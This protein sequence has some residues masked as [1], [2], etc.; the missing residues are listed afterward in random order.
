[1]PGWRVPGP[2]RPPRLR[3]VRDDGA[4][5]VCTHRRHRLRADWHDN[6]QVLREAVAFSEP[7]DHSLG[8]CGMGEVPLPDLLPAGQVVRLKVRLLVI[9]AARPVRVHGVD[10]AVLHHRQAIGHVGVPG[11][12]VAG[13]PE[14]LAVLG[15]QAVH[16]AD[17]ILEDYATV[18]CFHGHEVPKLREG[19]ELPEHMAIS[20][21]EAGHLP[22]AAAR[23]PRALR[24][25][26][27][28]AHSHTGDICAQRCG[29][30]RHPEA[31]AGRHAEGND[32]ATVARDKHAAVGQGRDAPRAHG[33]VP[34][35][36]AVGAELADAV[37][38]GKVNAL[39]V[40]DDN[41]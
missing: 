3:I 28:V 27:P 22:S 11:A 9:T 36:L 15:A 4:V 38:G 34:K 14:E 20:G 33:G 30:L 8:V 6:S 25:K 5:I 19:L 2:E 32:L 16:A 29:E 35:E 41:A 24:Q 17:L 21:I 13:V 12:R 10:H 23:A 18:A 37:S 1:M 39:L 40:I 26:H 31:L 7:R